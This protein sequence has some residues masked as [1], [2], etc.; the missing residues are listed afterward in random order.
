MGKKKIDI[1]EKTAR[2]DNIVSEVASVLEKY[3]CTDTE[4]KNL[5]TLLELAS[6]GAS[7]HKVMGAKLCMVLDD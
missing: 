2:T 7:E 1:I 5:A 3:N 4:V 6:E